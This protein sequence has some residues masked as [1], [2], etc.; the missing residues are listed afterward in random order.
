MLT[1]PARSSLSVGARTRRSS[2][3]SRHPVFLQ[4]RRAPLVLRR[5]N[6]FTN[7]PAGVDV[8]P[9]YLRSAVYAMMGEWEE[10]RV[11]WPSAD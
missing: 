7:L 9:G 6:L 11:S 8:G 10:R 5:H 2:Q 4:D 1:G 3:H